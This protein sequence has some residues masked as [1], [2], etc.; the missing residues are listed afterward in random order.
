MNRVPKIVRVVPTEE[1]IVYVYFEIS[2][3]MNTLKMKI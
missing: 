2:V 3:Y 1:Y